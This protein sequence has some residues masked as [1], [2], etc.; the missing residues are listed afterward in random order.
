LPVEVRQHT[1]SSSRASG[2]LTRG[3]LRPR[4]VDPGRAAP[5]RE[6][7]LSADPAQESS[8]LV[9]QTQVES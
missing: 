7:P 1:A 3:G 5:S 6:R 8:I 9:V 2:K 4:H